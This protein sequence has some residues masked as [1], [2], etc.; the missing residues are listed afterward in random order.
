MLQPR[1]SNTE[2]EPGRQAVT[3]TWWLFTAEPIAARERVEYDGRVYQVEGEPERWEPRPGRVHYE[4]N[5][6]RVDG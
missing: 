1:T 5:L 6:S 3:G 4:T 2:N